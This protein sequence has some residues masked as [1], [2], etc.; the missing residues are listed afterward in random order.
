MGEYELPPEFK[1]Q[2]KVSAVAMVVTAKS[3][4]S[5][6]RQE[7]DK[8]DDRWAAMHN[9]SWIRPISLPRCRVDPRRVRT[10]GP[11]LQDTDSIVFFLSK[12]LHQQ[13][14]F[15]L[16]KE[17]PSFFN[18]PVSQIFCPSS[19]QRHGPRVRDPKEEKPRFP[20]PWWSRET[21]R[22]QEIT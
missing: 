8:V 2:F 21:E 4:L 15:F 20:C 6:R 17:R 18:T 16:S 5:I 9:N 12:A 14:R 11:S 1:P 10:D 13:E 7:Q 22:R 3:A 19:A